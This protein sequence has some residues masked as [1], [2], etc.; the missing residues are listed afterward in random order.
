MG[1][2]NPSMSTRTPATLTIVGEHLEDDE[3]SFEVTVF[4]GPAG[5]L[6]ALLEGATE[7]LDVILWGLAEPLEV[8][9]GGIG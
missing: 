3:S 9:F 4:K 1:C 8:V 7:P 2:E 5:P 6:G